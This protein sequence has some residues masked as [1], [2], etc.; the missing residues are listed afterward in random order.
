MKDY[1][2]SKENKNLFILN[3]E[4][5]DNQIIVNVANGKHYAVGYTEENE[6]I[7]LKRMEEQ[8]KE[9]GQRSKIGLSCQYY[10]SIFAAGLWGGLA[11]Y[12]GIKLIGHYG[13]PSLEGVYWALAI[14]NGSM[15]VIGTASVVNAKRKLDDIK[16]NMMFLDN[17]KLFKEK[18]RTDDEILSKDITFEQTVTINDIHDMSIEQVD[19]M[20]NLAK[21]SEE[22]GMI[23]SPVV[24]KRIKKL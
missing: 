5:V 23:A 15:A 13:N 14:G 8:V 10:G 6:K 16:K 20:I 21:F 2:S 19:D 18:V 1:S 12:N 24:K 9:D 4:I 3:Y 7:I 17:K 22:T 11:V